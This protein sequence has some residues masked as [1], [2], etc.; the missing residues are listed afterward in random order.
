MS[1]GQEDDINDGEQGKVSACHIALSLGIVQTRLTYI[2][3][4]HTTEQSFGTTNAHED[5]IK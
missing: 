2:V 1:E 3:S 5:V 4:S